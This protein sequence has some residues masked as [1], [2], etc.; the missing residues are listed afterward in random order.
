ML[1]RKPRTIHIDSN[2]ASI[3]AINFVKQSKTD[4]LYQSPTNSIKG[5][6]TNGQNGY[7]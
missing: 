7:H 1:G 2:N 6:A 3:S 5:V 4:I